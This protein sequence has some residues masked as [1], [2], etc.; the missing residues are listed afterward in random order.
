MTEQI[1]SQSEY[2]DESESLRKTLEQMRKEAEDEV[3]RLNRRLAEREFAPDSSVATATERLAMQQEMMVLQQTLEAK[4]QALDHITEECRRLE[5]QIED[6]NMV[7]DGLKQEVERKDR[8]VKELESELQNLR[9][10]VR[11]LERRVEEPPP[12]VVAPT[13]PVDKAPPRKIPT[14]WILIGALVMFVFLS[15][16]MLSFLYLFWDRIH[17]RLPG[18]DLG[19]GSV[20]TQTI[21]AQGTSSFPPVEAD[22]GRPLESAADP[23]VTAEPVPDDVAAASPG[24]PPRIRNDRLSNGTLGPPMILIEGGAFTMGSTSPTG[25]DFSPAHEVRVRPFW[26]G[27]HEVTFQEYD[28]FAR[29][30]GISPPDDRGWGRGSRP[31]VGV[32]WNDAGAYVAWLSRETG[33]AYRL[34]TEAEWEY[35]ARAS[36]DTPYWWGYGMTPGRAVCFDCGTRWDNRSTAPVGSF[37]ANPFGLFDTAGNAMEWVDDCYNG[38]YRG[39]PSDG[40]SWLAGDCSQRV[41]RGGAFNKPSSSMRSYVRSHFASGARLNMIGFRVARDL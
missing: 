20:A 39:A 4:E 17:I 25:E 38:S 36:T 35:A 15:A 14:S 9:D 27:Q 18:L 10:E 37:P 40:R 28:R 23:V 3:A 41:A 5:D 24:I 8:Q 12:V 31:V 19:G 22:A 1:D 11:M 29:A 34:P 6:Q 30:S 13:A 7:C 21:V 33:R 32:S 2:E 26:I 16:G